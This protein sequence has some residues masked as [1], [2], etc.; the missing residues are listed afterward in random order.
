MN[1]KSDVNSALRENSKGPSATTISTEA[2]FH[3]DS[4]EGTLNIN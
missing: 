4:N 3:D 1:F 2:S